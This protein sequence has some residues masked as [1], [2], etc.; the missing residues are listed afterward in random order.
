VN[1]DLSNGISDLSMNG[2]PSNKAEQPF[3][4]SQPILPTEE[5]ESIKKWR[6]EHKLALSEKDA[7]EKIKIEELKDQGKKELED[8]YARYEEQLAKAKQQNR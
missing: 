2:G 5:P 8:W 6:E 4:F 3:P 7:N 1:N